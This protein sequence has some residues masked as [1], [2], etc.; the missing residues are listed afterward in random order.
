MEVV[1]LPSVEA[2]GRVAADVVERTLT[3]VDE[4]VLGLATGGTPRPLYAELARRHRDEGLSF[5]AARAFLLDEYVGLPPEHPASYRSFLLHELV[6]HTDLDP[7]KL[8][9]PE[10]ACAGE[11]LTQAARDYEATLHE[12]GGVD[13]QLLGIGGDGHIGFN[14]PMSS[15]ASRTRIKTLTADT[16]RDN[17]R[18]FEG[19]LVDVPRHVMTQ[20]IA[21]VLDARHVLLLATGAAKA[22][23]VALAVEGPLAAL[24]PASAL[25][26]HPHATVLLDE[27]AASELRHTDYYRQAFEGKPTW[28]AL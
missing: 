3:T 12:A 10:T 7:A 8:R 27:A 18:F 20:G 9:G 11:A 16:R 23:P 15:L 21:T 4:P 25:Q 17:A 1:I 28:Q 14:E 19:G 22:A 2:V 13:L 5:A 26:L 6:E 24:V